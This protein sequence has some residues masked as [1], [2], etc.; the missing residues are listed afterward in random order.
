MEITNKGKDI[1]N[2]YLKVRAKYENRP[3]RYRKD[4][5]KFEYFDDIQKLER[6]F[7]NY[8]YI[9][10]EKFLSAPYEIW[11]DRK[12][13]NLDF[14]N[15]RRALRCYVDYKKRLLT[16]HPDEDIHI[17]SMKAGF[18]FI[19]HFCA[20]RGITIDDYINYKDGIYSFLQHLKEDSV[21]IYT[22][23]AFDEFKNKLKNDVDS[24]LKNMLY[25]DLYINYDY[26]YRMYMT[27][28]KC[29]EIS[30]KCLTAIKKYGKI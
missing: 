3:F 4:F 13:Y 14:Y 8:P 20:D 15:K 29:K 19:Y 7:N 9:N 1:Y 27:S 6:F 30:Q 24:E 11:Q 10:I 12:S 16:L 28:K 22:L 2:T 17:D 26:M 21:S 18:S 5:S 23:F 25:S